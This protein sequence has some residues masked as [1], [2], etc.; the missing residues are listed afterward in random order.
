MWEKG[1][2]KQRKEEKRKNEQVDCSIARV[3]QKGTARWIQE[4]GGPPSK[5]GSQYTCDGKEAV[6]G[7]RKEKRKRRT[8]QVSGRWQ[9][10]RH[11]NKNVKLIYGLVCQI[12]CHISICKI[13]CTCINHMLLY[14]NLYNN[15]SLHNSCI[16]IY[17]YTILV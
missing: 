15:M 13:F 1:I 3:S 7:E 10:R 16:I 9:G 12:L 8:R 5:R 6:S 2:S 17:Y 11:I 14:K 4:K